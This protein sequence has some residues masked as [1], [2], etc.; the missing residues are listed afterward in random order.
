MEEYRHVTVL[1]NEAV[2]ALNVTGDGIYVDG[3]FGRGGHSRLILSKLSEKGRLFGIDRDPEAVKAGMEIKDPRFTMLRGK[4]SEMPELLGEFGV[5]GKI[6]GILLDLGVSSPQLDDPER[7]FSFMKEGPLDMRMD[8]ESGISAADWI[9]S[10]PESEIAEVIRNYGEERFA[11]KIARAVVQDRRDHPFRTTSELADLVSRLVPR[12]PGKNPATR[13]FQALR[14]KVNGEL[15]EIEKAL[16]NSRDLLA[17]F[18]RL[19]VIT[20]HSLEDHLVRSFLKKAERGEVPPRGIPVPESEIAKTR[21]F[22]LVDRGIRPGAQEISENPRSRS[23]ILRTGERLPSCGTGK[24]GG[25]C[26]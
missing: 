1:L 18:G 4:F 12:E 17:P 11:R 10:A 24:D 16:R 26:L 2:A 21:T 22:R 20:F 3:T 25:R 6:A 14:I 13:T 15:E 9:N 7:G 5:L 23:A 8:P 19:A